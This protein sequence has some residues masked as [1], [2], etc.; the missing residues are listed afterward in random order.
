MTTYRELK[1]KVLELI[2]QYSVG[3]AAVSPDYNNQ[4]DYI[5]R[6]PGL[7][8]DALQRIRTEARP[9]VD[10]RSFSNGGTRYGDMTLY[11]LPQ[12]Y[13]VVKTGGV[14]R[15]SDGKF[16]PFGGYRL[17]GEQSILF[18]AD[19]ASYMMEYYCAPDYIP[20]DPDDESGTDEDPEILTAACYF[21]AAMLSVD[22]KRSRVAV[23]L[24]RQRGGQS[25]MV[26]LFRLCRG[27]ALSGARP[28]LSPERVRTR[29]AIRPRVLRLRRG[30]P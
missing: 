20:E 27:H 7:I 5:G 1:R 2:N 10:V 28:F 22:R 11:S 6:I 4:S 17:L 26:P 15:I 25:R 9:R 13:R 8:N 30:N 23:G 24:L 16:E 29:H 18:P 21:A 3:G 14:Y 19:G 12:E